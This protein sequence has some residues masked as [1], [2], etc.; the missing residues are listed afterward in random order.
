MEPMSGKDRKIEFVHQALRFTIG[1][2]AFVAG[3]DKFFDLLTDW[4]DYL[5]PEASDKLPMKTHDFMRLVGVIEMAVGGLILAGRTRVGGYLAGVWLAGIAANLVVNEN[6]DIAARD[7]NM[8][9]A[10]IALAQIS[11][12]RRSARNSRDMSMERREV[13]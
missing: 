6:Y 4:D 11:G 5:S 3:L 9:V 7:V 8:A 13:A 12:A 10:A 1:G 2:T